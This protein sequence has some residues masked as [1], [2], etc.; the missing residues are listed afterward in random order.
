MWP[1]SARRKVRSDAGCGLAPSLRRTHHGTRR[2]R[3]ST[4]LPPHQVPSVAPLF[5]AAERSCGY[6]NRKHLRPVFGEMRVRDVAS[7]TW[8]PYGVRS[9]GHARD[10]FEMAG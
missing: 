8:T 4:T 3:A 7:R 2:G 10:P 1:H 9:W 6:S 5:S